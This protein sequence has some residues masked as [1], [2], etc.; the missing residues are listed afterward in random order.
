MTTT[1]WTRSLLVG[2]LCVAGALAAWQT[3]ALATAQQAASPAAP[4][5]IAVINLQ[6]ASEQLDELKARMND[7]NERVKAYQKQ[8]DEAVQR[9]RIVEDDLRQLKPGD[10]R[11]N[12]KRVELFEARSAAEARTAALK[13]VIDSEKGDALLTV[14]Q[15]LAA[16]AQDVADREGF[17]VVLTYDPKLDLGDEVTERTVQAA[18]SVRQVLYANSRVDITRLVVTKMNNDFAANKG[19]R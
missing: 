9:W 12:T 14:Y 13:R 18:T 3:A 19:K 5:R 1:S 16:A 17:D 10:A 7:F 2:T 15:R 6:A 4:T 11:L 8:V